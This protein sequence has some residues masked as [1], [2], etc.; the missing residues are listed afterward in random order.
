[1]QS[2]ATTLTGVT[3][4]VS[5]VLMLVSLTRGQN[6]DVKFDITEELPIN[7]PVGSVSQVVSLF[8]DLTAR[9][10]QSLKFDILSQ[11]TPPAS[12]FN[13][14]HTDGMIYVA[15]RIDREEQ[16]FAQKNCIFLINILASPQSPSEFDSR[17][18]TVHFR[19]LDINDNAPTFNTESVSLEI[20]ER[21]SVGAVLKVSG[22]TDRDYKPEFNVKNYTLSNFQDVFQLNSVETLDGSSEIDLKLLKSLDREVRDTYQF[23]ITAYDGGVPPKSQDLSVTVHVTDQNDNDP[24]FENAT[25]SVTIDRDTPPSTVIMRVSATDADAGNNARLTYDFSSVQ[26]L[27]LDGVFGING[28]T[29]DISVLGPLQSGVTE[30]IVE[31]Q[32]SGSPRLKTQTIVT[33]NV[34]KTGNL[35]P[36]VSIT[37]VGA[38]SQKN[39]VSVMEPGG[40]N[41]FVAFVTVSDDSDDPVRCE[42]SSGEVFRM[43]TIPNKGYQI[44][45]QGLV[46]REARET[47]NLTVVCVDQGNPPLN[48]SASVTVNVQDANDNT[49]EFTQSF[50]QKKIKEG[51]KNGEYLLQV[52]AT[53][54]DIGLNGAIV[55][56]ID[57]EYTQYFSINPGTGVLSAVGLLDRETHSVLDFKVYATDRGDPRNQGSADV[58]ITIEDVNDNAPEFTR[59]VFTIRTYEEQKGGPR[60]VGELTARDADAGLNGQLEF[61]FTASLDGADRVFSVLPNGSI[62]SLEKLDRE[63]RVNYSF[64]VMVR[65]KGSPPLKA[66]ASVVVDVLDINDNSPMILFPRSQNHT[67][68]ISSVPETGVVLSRIIAYD[69]DAGDNGS[70]KFTIVSGNEDNAFEIDDRTG[71]FRISDGERLKNHRQYKVGVLVSD[72]G[73]P[74]RYNSTAIRVDVQ[75][76]NLTLDFSQTDKDRQEDYIIIVAVVAAVTFI[77]STVIIVAICVVFH[78]DRSSRRKAGSGGSAGL[79][80]PKHAGFKN[81]TTPDSLSED[82]KALGSPRVKPVPS[83]PLNNLSGPANSGLIP[84]APSDDDDGAFFQVHPP[85]PDH[86]D[87]PA[88]GKAVSFSLDSHVRAERPAALSTFSGDLYGPRS[89]ASRQVSAVRYAP[90]STVPSVHGDDVTS[91]TSGDTTTSD[92]GRGNSIDDVNFDQIMKDDLSPKL[93]PHRHRDDLHLPPRQ[94]RAMEANPARASYHVRFAQ[95]AGKARSQNPPALPPKQALQPSNSYDGGRPLSGVGSS[96]KLSRVDAPSNRSASSAVGSSNTNHSGDKLASKLSNST[97]YNNNSSSSSGNNITASLNKLQKSLSANLS[98]ARQMSVNSIDDDATTTTSGSYVIN[99]DDVRMEALVGSDIIV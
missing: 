99:P 54:K 73:V 48:A 85:R 44:V 74:P 9:Q 2:K 70:L 62:Q 4:V 60:I 12:L 95:H 52:S 11:A 59:K 32:D 89:H 75:Y 45:L 83:F 36:L 25:Y 41:L 21:N 24:V 86:G 58:S 66:S 16:C 81:L 18:V 43:E 80:G 47:Y 56:S 28:S 20:P 35:A 30:I 27:V 64:S 97:S 91:D 23:T 22:A 84:S 31:A 76:S 53:D 42:I 5:L 68:L 39:S 92:S 71:E 19:V 17:V 94:S 33:V 65:D 77:F 13:I 82:E 7:S 98:T 3:R 51:R 67:V 10:K 72:R 34:M 38:N 40:R 1:M 14:S 29:G 55:Y 79:G 87:P 8:S 6:A 96:G 63:E 78:K 90:V 69:D 50:Y 93:I 15:R 49:P 37:T 46:D 61:L 26:K 88:R 57:P